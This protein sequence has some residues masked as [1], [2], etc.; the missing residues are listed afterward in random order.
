MIT[1]R[2]TGT[3]PDQR[4]RLLGVGIATL[5]IINTLAEYP[6]EDTE[7]RALAQRRTRGGNA[8]NSLTVLAQLGHEC[9]W[10]GTLA[11]DAAGDFIRAD[12]HRQGIGL[13]LDVR[14]PETTTP[15]SYIV[16]SQATGS[17]TIVHYRDLP[18]LEAATFDRVALDGFDWVHFEGRHPSETHRMIA[19]VRAECPGARISVELEK[20]R[21]GI[22]SLLDGPQVLLVSRAYALALGFET[23]ENCLR[24][25]ASRTSAE[26]IVLGW[27]AEGAR[28][29]TRGLHGL[30]NTLDAVPAYSPRQ[31]VDTLGAGDC[32]NAAIIDGLLCGLD[33][34]TT[35]ERAVWLAGFKCGR[36]GLEGLIS[37]A[38]R[39]GFDPPPG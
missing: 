5:D 17:R 16:L 39:A 30:G 9:H 1:D 32:L 2:S 38:N 7:V 4:R 21:P 8:A 33:P 34:E 10:C 22:E 28:Y 20:L 25:L 23:P 14:L 31:V 26:L 12:L 3:H 19:R 27:G 18:E 24:D 36:H 6:S 37:E 29:L 13:A 35:V 15:T 11:D